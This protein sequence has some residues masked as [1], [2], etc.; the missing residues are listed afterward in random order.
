M[1]I[2][3]GL[4]GGGL[5]ADL[6][7]WWLVPLVA[8]MMAALVYVVWMWMTIWPLG[9]QE[10]AR[11][12]RAEDLGRTSADVVLLSASVASLL[13]LGLVLIRA[14]KLMGLEKGLLIGGGV[15][16]VVLSW[17]VVHTVFTLR[18][19]DLYYDGEAGGV[20][21]KEDDSPEFSDFA[22]L[23]WTIGMTF[24][25]SDTDLKTKGMRRTALRHALLSYM[26]G[27]LIIATTINLV[28]GLISK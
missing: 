22:Y 25:V 9:A 28:A 11:R 15:L 18:Y 14:A 1:S 7:P 21:F 27:A 24:Q 12:A 20:D 16:S 2:G 4:L 26:F 10:T 13:A 8:W 19:A 23:A 5:A 17:A 6:G 3:S